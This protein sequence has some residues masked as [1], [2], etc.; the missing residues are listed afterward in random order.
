MHMNSVRL[1][2]LKVVLCLINI[3]S[4][5]FQ[6]EKII[7]INFVLELQILVRMIMILGQLTSLPIT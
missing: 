1:V 7:P 4:F 3:R 5:W 6:S 2:M